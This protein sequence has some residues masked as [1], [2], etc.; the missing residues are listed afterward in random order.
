MKIKIKQTSGWKFHLKDIAGK[1]VNVETDYLFP[2]QFNTETA[3]VM[4]I[5]VEGI[6]DD[7]RVGRIMDRR[8]NKNYTLSELPAEC[9]SEDRRPFLFVFTKFK[10]KEIYPALHEKRLFKN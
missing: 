3:R 2:G 1:W 4:M 10:R 5:D 7:V 9:F 8:T 6:K